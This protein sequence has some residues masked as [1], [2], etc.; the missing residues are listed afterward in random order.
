MIS[1][2]SFLAGAEGQNTARFRCPDW[3]SGKSETERPFVLLYRLISL[4]QITPPGDWY[5]NRGYAQKFFCVLM[6]DT[7][8]ERTEQKH[9]TRET[10]REFVIGMMML[11]LIGALDRSSLVLFHSVH[12]SR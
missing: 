6:V 7:Q 8:T 11:M 4:A 5:H 9:C 1:L 12:G 10:I 3:E 2:A